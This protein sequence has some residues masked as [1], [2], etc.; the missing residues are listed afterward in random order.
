MND[1]ELYPIND[2]RKYS[3]EEM[4]QKLKAT[5][6][7]DS[8]ESDFQKKFREAKEKML[9]EYREQA[10]RAIW[11]GFGY[12][13]IPIQENR[14]REARRLF[15]EFKFNKGNLFPPIPP[16]PKASGM[17]LN[18]DDISLRRFKHRDRRLLLVP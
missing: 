2:T 8:E 9:N 3:E 13:D 18:T 15:N 4:K 5:W 7:I 16:E 14:L 17:F 1:D 10:E 11:G 12:V 6:Q